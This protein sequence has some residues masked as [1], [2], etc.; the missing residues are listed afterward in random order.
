MLIGGDWRESS[1]AAENPT[2]R[3]PAPCSSRRAFVA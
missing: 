3:L 1:D 2:L